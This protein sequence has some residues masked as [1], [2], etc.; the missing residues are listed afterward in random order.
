MTAFRLATA[1]RLAAVAAF[2]SVLGVAHAARTIVTIAPPE[3]VVEQV[4]V[5]PH[6]GWVYRP[7]YYNWID[8][9]Y[10]WI[11]GAWAAPRVGYRWHP[12][13]W[14]KERGGWRLHAGYWAR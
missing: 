14:V 3:P 13:A 2:A 10:V 5:A 4:G 12:H 6:P 1:R 9:R 7:G 8:G 11:N